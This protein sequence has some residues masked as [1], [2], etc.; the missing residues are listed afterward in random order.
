MSNSLIHSFKPVIFKDTTTLILG[1]FPSLKSIENNFYYSNPQNQFWKILSIITG[2]PHLIK[3]QKM[4]LLKKTNIG[5]WD[6]LRSYNIEHK[7][8]DRDIYDEDINDIAYL[9][10]K[11]PHINKI[12]FTGRKS[13]YLFEHHFG[14]LEIER[15]YLPS[16][17]IFH[18]K[19]D[20]E[21][22]AIIYKEKLDI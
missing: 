18:S 8:V 15:V 12:A 7:S 16:P 3:D 22:K 1:S 9:L 14:Y 19:I 17:S 6:M 13:E 11:H 4:W 2:Y 20:I 5:L 10:E 21:N